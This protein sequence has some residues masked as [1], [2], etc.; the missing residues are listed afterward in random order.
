MI[1]CCVF[2]AI[3]FYQLEVQY[4]FPVYLITCIK[5]KIILRYCWKFLLFCRVFVKDQSCNFFYGQYR[6]FLHLQN[7]FTVIIWFRMLFDTF[8][9]EK[10]FSTVCFLRLSSVIFSHFSIRCVD[11]LNIFIFQTKVIFWPSALHFSTFY[12][13]LEVFALYCPVCP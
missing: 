9:L 12:C 13:L 4:N 11:I 8:L 6:D 10:N 3:K 5:Y 2:G 7:F 1:S